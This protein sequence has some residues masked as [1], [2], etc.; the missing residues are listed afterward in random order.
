MA[1]DCELRAIFGRKGFHQGL[2]YY[3]YSAVGIQQTEILL[4]IPIDHAKVYFNEVACATY[5][6]LVSNTTQLSNIHITRQLGSI[7]DV[8]IHIP[9]YRLVISDLQVFIT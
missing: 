8:H 2:C 9:I 7:T 3:S 6:K 1:E 5:G 4:G